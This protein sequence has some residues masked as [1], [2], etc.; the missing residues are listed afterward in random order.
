MSISVYAKQ[1]E[2][3]SREM[4]TLSLRSSL[5]AQE[6]RRMTYLT[7]QAATYRSLIA[8]QSAIEGEN[9]EE[10]EYKRSFRNYVRAGKMEQRTYQAME[11]IDLS[12]GGA[13]VPQDYQR[14]LFRGIGIIEPLFDDANVRFIRTKNGRT[15]TVPGID[16][17]AMT[18]TITTQNADF[19]PVANP[20]LSKS[21]FGAYSYRVSPIVISMEL[22]Q[23]SFEPV[24]DLL[25]D[26]FSVGYSMGIGA[27]LALGTG[28]GEPLGIIT[29]ATDSG[30]TTDTGVI[31]ED[32][33]VNVYFSLP[34][35]HRV[36]PKTAWV[37]SDAQYELVRKITDSAGRPM[38]NIV[39][40]QEQLLGKKVLVSPALASQSKFCLANLSQYVVRVAT[41][42]V[43]IRRT[44]EQSPYAEQGSYLLTSTMRVDGRLVS[45]ASS[46]A[47]AVFGTVGS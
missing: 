21:T 33:L 25:R 20:V 15:L 13:L 35:L 17:T 4:E 39:N 45:P 32:D 30:V 27:D 46:V 23:D 22:E 7:S 8:A 3:V 9:P 36:N 24:E 1:L 12:L 18:A 10:R 34:R 38:L 44:S 16:L 26:A 6:D 40:D 43:R 2:S 28:S 42:S 29:A 41:E 19:A 14:E 11:S 47:P 37:F 31:A 5:N